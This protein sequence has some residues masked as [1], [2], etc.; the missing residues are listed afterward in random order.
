MDAGH[1]SFLQTLEAQISATKIL[2]LE[3]HV[4]LSVNA[5]FRHFILTDCCNLMDVQHPC[6]NVPQNI[7]QITILLKI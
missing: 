2:Y 6:S 5:N 3:L 1:N 4:F 7:M